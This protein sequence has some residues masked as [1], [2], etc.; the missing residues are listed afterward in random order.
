MRWLAIGS[1][2]LAICALLFAFRE[3]SPSTVQAIGVGPDIALGTPS[4][5]SVPVLAT[6]SAV[7]PY[8]GFNV[9]FAYSASAAVSVTGVGFSVV[10]SLL[11][12]PSDLFCSRLVTPDTLPYDR[13]VGCTNIAAG[14]S[15]SA[16]LLLSV[17]FS[18]S[19]DGC[20][21][22]RLQNT[23][24]DA[25][26]GTYTVDAWDI[27]PQN[28][29]VDTTS[30]RAVLV[31]AGTIAECPNGPAATPTATNTRTL[32]TPTPT[33][34]V[35]GAPHVELGD[36]ISDGPHNAH[37]PVTLLIGSIPP[38]SAFN[39]HVAAYPSSGVTVRDI[40]ASSQGS[41]SATGPLSCVTFVPTAT[42]G[43][44]AAVAS[45]SRRC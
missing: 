40:S 27:T 42:E 35:V 22:I 37:V 25:N 3:T 2:A 41:A 26:L 39:V 32:D 24:G 45:S 17:T 15:I 12:A 23:P 18:A 34:Q 14:S 5:A 6:T 1:G 10:G 11:G 20:V 16:G 33:P 31:G 19:G 21:L 30:Q 43:C 28:N 29:V 7:A 13:V 9:H 38:F 36:A 8:S 4:G 44:L